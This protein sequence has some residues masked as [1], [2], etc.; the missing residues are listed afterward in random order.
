MVDEDLSML[1]LGQD[2]T[3]L[4]LKVD[5]P[6]NGLHKTFSSPWT[7]H[8]A[9]G[10]KPDFEIPACYKVSPVTSHSQPDW[11][12]QNAAEKLSPEHLAKFKDETL[13]FVFYSSPGEEA[14]AMA[15]TVLASRGLTW[16]KDRK[17]WFMRV[18]NMHPQK[19]PEGERGSYIFFDTSKWKYIQKDNFLIKYEAVESGNTL[20]RV[21]LQLA[22]K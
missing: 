7:Y 17:Q 15:S 13:F 11:W 16:H 4:G 2:L 1:A 22:M 19:I 3:V 20:S 10:P 18:P 6:G 9:P 21:Q 14:Q 12:L 8:Q 5:D